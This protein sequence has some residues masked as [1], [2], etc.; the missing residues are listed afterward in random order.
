MHFELTTDQRDFAASLESLLAASDTP[1]VARAWADGAE[2]SG[3]T[4]VV[5]TSGRPA[6]EVAALVAGALAE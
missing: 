4:V 3:A 1:A 6:D 5:V 2:P